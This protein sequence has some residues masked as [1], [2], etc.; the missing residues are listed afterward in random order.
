[1]GL[2][3][4]SGEC[5]LNSTEPADAGRNDEDAV[6]DKLLLALCG[7]PPLG[8][9]PFVIA[10]GAELFG[11]ELSE[12]YACRETLPFASSPQAS[13]SRKTGLN[14][15][16]KVPM[17]SVAEGGGDGNPTCALYS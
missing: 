17:I 15:R 2:V 13:T 12:G 14:C 6:T 5:S 3:V 1:M 4:G 9:E 7:Y 16:L 8:T 11:T 10:F